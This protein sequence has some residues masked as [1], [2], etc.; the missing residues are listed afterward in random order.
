MWMK[1]SGLVYVPNCVVAARV[2]ES[3]QVVN[4]DKSEN[5]Q[6]VNTDKEKDY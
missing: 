4:I 2:G 5:S 1:T 3:S 6:V